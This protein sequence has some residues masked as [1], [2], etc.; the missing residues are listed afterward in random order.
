MS[1]VSNCWNL[2]PPA[3]WSF[4]G[5][6]TGPLASVQVKAHS[7]N[8]LEVKTHRSGSAVCVGDQDEAVSSVCLRGVSLT[9]KQTDLSLSQPPFSLSFP[10]FFPPVHL[11]RV[12]TL[13]WN[14]LITARRRAH[15]IWGFALK[16][17]ERSLL[18]TAVQWGNSEVAALSLSTLRLLWLLPKG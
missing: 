18:R 5:V 14:S 9:L 11:L 4:D 10:L 13:D 7:W 15:S 6:N 12:S 1:R 8:R 16:K 17:R 2:T 3:G